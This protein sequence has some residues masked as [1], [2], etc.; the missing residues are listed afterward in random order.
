MK[1]SLNHICY[2]LFTKILNVNLKK[3]KKKNL[4]EF[5]HKRSL[6]GITVTGFIKFDISIGYMGM[7]HFSTVLYMSGLEYSQFIII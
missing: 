4:T 3:K 5:P 1:K 2:F 6:Q 7:L